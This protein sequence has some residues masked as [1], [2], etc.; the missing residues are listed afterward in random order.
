LA[1]CSKAD[2][3]RILFGQIL[4]KYLIVEIRHYS[5]REAGIGTSAVIQRWHPDKARLF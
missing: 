4:K 1:Y 3:L 2:I 5:T